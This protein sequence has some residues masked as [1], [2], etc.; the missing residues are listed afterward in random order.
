MV[1]KEKRKRKKKVGFDLKLTPR[2][3]KSIVCF[4]FSGI[5]YMLV[6]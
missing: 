6:S 2:G 5:N 4:F 1:K 3:F